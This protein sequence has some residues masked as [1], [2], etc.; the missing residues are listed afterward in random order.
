VPDP[1]I[2]TA[3]NYKPP[4]CTAFAGTTAEGRCLSNCLVAVVQQ[5]SLE[6]STCNAAL[7][8]CAPCYD[9]FSGAATGACTTVSCDLP[10]Q[11]KYTFPWCCN[12]NGIAEGRCIPKT[13]VPSGQQGSLNQDACPSNSYLCVPLENLPGGRGQGCHVSFTPVPPFN[14]DGSCISNCVNLGLGT[15]YPQAN[16]PSNHTCI[17]CSSAP[18]GSAGC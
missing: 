8:H 9:P 4:A 12:D 3:D 18:G 2:S 17:P 1:I 10:T 14:Y 7:E 11:P 5:P 16:C 13:Q 6:V 15:L